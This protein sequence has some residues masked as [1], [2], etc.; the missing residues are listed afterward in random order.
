M[1]SKFFSTLGLC[2]RAG[3]L[4]YGYDMV[5]EALDHPYAVFFATGLS[6]RTRTSVLQLAVRKNI[7]CKDLDCD[8]SAL[9]VAIGTKPVGVIG[10][11]EKGFAK[12]LG[13]TEN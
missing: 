5:T 8:M 11:T 10:I 6:K 12:L 13:G 4:T 1:E 7:P 9:A 2:R 3:K